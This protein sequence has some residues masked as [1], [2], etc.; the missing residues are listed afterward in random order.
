M[1]SNVRHVSRFI[2]RAP[3]DV[4]RFLG[5]P[6]NLPQWASGVSKSIHRENDVWI[7]DS[8][9]GRVEFRFVPPND[10]GV[11]DHD[12]KLPNGETFYNPMRVFANGKGSEL[13]F[14]VIQ[15]E[16]MSDEELEKDCRT[17]AKDLEAAKSLLESQKTS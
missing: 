12:V 5:D 14:T 15:R 3:A 7:C 10:L 11:L 2:D 8:P 1:G 13:L 16:G 9:M 17:I 4:V 6:N